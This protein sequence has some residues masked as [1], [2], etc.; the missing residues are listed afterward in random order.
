MEE[1]GFMNNQSEPSSLVT[2]LTSVWLT[3]TKSS[4][5][6]TIRREVCSDMNHIVI[7]IGHELLAHRRYRIS[8]NSYTRR[9][10]DTC[11]FCVGQNK[12][13]QNSM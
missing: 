12:F 4:F 5:F 10:S 2:L 3:F 13:S 7:A 8:R 1:E 9:N 6:M 11:I